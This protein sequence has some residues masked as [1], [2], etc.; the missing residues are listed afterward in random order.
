M[1]T[2][3]SPLHLD[4][5]EAEVE[6]VPLLP[7]VGWDVGEVEG[8]AEAEVAQLNHDNVDGLGVP[9]HQDGWGQ[10]THIDRDTQVLGL[11]ILHLEA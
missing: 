2:Y 4:V 9:R 8:V 10:Q 11:D 7:H 5:V 3:H 1:T 6:V